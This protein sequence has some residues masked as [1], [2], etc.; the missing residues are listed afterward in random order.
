MARSY[1]LK[2]LGYTGKFKNIPKI[3]SQ[4]QRFPVVN[5]SIMNSVN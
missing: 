3:S 4:Q 1:V 5:I 2:Q